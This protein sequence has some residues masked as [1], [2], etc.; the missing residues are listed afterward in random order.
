M[1]QPPEAWYADP[2]DP[3]RLRWWDGRQWTGHTVPLQQ[4]PHTAAGAAVAVYRPARRLAT[5]AVI[6]ALVVVLIELLLTALSLPSYNQISD[7]VG[8]GRDGSSDVFTRYDAVALL[9]LP[10]EIAAYVVTCLW[11]WRARVNAEALNG[12]S[13]QVR[14]RGW[15]WGGW[16]CPVVNWWFPYQVVRDIVRATGRGRYGVGAWWAWFVAWTLVGNVAVRMGADG[17]FPVVQWA[18]A[19]AAIVAGA[20]WV[21]VV[22]GV[23]RDQHEYASQQGT[24][25]A[26]AV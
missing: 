22:R 21:R 24:G 7:A 19:L 5:A 26:R 13:G 4:Q 9:Q 1:S 8:E 3:A 17:S 12:A 6:V 11:L 25:E 2:A 23:T 16:V 14:G 15:A 20:K 10:C 18:S